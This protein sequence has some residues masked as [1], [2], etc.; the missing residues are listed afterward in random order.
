MLAGKERSFKGAR[1]YPF[2]Q[3]VVNGAPGRDHIV[4]EDWLARWKEGRIGWHEAA[5]NAALRGHWP[6]LPPGARML[7]PLCGKS[8]DLAWLAEQGLAVTGVELS[9]I[10]I[11]AFLAEQGLTADVGRRGPFDVYTVRGRPIELWRGDF[12]DFA[13]TGFDALYDRG[14]LV[15]LPPDLRLAYVE[16]VER[17]LRPGATRLVITLEY[18]QARAAGPPFS[19]LADE[20]L[21]YWPDLER[22]SAREDLAGAPPKFREAGLESVVEAVWLSPGGAKGR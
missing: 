1:W 7:V 16:R 15:A 22:V 18:D 4:T 8:Y 10:A 17:C 6:E 20:V 3:C 5:G 9:A 11:S 13:G 19:V 14:A 2:A 12:F 21:A